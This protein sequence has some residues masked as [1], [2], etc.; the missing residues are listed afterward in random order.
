[1]S[2]KPIEQ[3]EDVHSSK[4]NHFQFRRGFFAACQP[5]ELL[6]ANAIPMTTNFRVTR[7]GLPIQM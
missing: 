7:T 6:I 2:L 5:P 4:V 1:M 3:D